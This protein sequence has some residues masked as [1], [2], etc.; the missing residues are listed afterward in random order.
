MTKCGT[1]SWINSREVDWSISEE[2][3]ARQEGMR[4]KDEFLVQRRLRESRVLDGN[5]TSVKAVV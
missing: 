4:E 5:E 2:D 3:Q 1:G